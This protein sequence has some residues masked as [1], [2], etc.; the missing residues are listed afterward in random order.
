MLIR[1]GDSGLRFVERSKKKQS[2]I[3]VHRDE[4]V[5]LVGAV[6]EVMNGVIL[7]VRLASIPRPSRADVAPSTS[8]QK[9]KKKKFEFLDGRQKHPWF[10]F[11]P[12]RSSRSFFSFP[13][14][15][16]SRS[17]SCLRSVHPAPLPLPV[18]LRG[19]ASRLSLSPSVASRSL[20]LQRQFSGDPAG[21]KSRPKPA[22]VL[23]RPKV[24]CSPQTQTAARFSGDPKR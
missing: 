22:T 17:R 5:W 21:T 12:F 9:K 8:P 19:V 18:T 23:R 11:P 15:F 1:G 7:S 24:S 2:S 14:P 13:L 10:L 3:F 6:E 20:S 16:V 4:L